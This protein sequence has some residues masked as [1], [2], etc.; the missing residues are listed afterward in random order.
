MRQIGGLVVVEREAEFTLVRAE[1]V[2]HKVGILLE[3]DGL[4]GEG[5]QTLAPVAVRLRVGGGA[6]RARLGPHTVLEVHHLGGC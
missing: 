5:R 2:A 3:V 6:A 4:G 1:V